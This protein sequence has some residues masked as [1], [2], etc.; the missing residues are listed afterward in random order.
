MLGYHE[1]L[2]K[3]LYAAG[4]FFIIPSR[5]EPCGLTDFIAQL[6]GNIPIVR[7][8]GGLVKVKDGLNGLVFRSEEPSDLAASMNRAVA[9][10]SE[11]P[12]TLHA[13]QKQAVQIIMEKYTWD[14]VVLKY[15]DLYHRAADSI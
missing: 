15:L 6:M 7:H 4:D 12:G 14:K 2:A 3:L 9:I 8:T 11:A 13:M 5:Y 10:Y 1:K